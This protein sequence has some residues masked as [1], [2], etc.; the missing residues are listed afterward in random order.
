MA[1]ARGR[2]A[3]DGVFPRSELLEHLARV[4]IYRAIDWAVERG[5]LPQEVFYFDQFCGE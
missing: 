5:Q 1:R 3:T 2:R 4:D